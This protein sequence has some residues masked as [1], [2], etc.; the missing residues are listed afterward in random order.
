MPNYQIEWVSSLD[1]RYGTAMHE[2]AEAIAKEAGLRVIDTY[3]GSNGLT[4][5]NGLT[6]YAVTMAIPSEVAL[7]I[8]QRFG[9]TVNVGHHM[10]DGSTSVLST[11]IAKPKEKYR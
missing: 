1:D 2:Q 9:Y 11:A 5:D 6:V 3:G 7:K 10:P 4:A 8:A